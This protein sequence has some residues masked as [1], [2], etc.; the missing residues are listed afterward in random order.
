ME[1]LNIGVRD[2]YLEEDSLC[3][4]DLHLNSHPDTEDGTTVPLEDSVTISRAFVWL[5]LCAKG[6]HFLC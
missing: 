4:T 2:S 1:V 5:I 6:I 3:E